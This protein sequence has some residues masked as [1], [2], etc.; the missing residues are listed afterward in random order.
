MSADRV[1]HLAR[2]A[3]APE[4][5]ILGLMSG[6]SLDGIDAALVR[7]GGSGPD[8]RIT[9]EGF[10]STPFEPD[11]RAALRQGLHGSVRE[12]CE[13][14]FAF[15][16][17]LAAASLACLAELGVDPGEVDLIASHGQT[18]WHVDPFQQGTPS[19]LQVGSPAVLAARTGCVVISD[20]RSADI[21]HGGRGAPLVSYLDHCLF[22]RPDEV[23]LLQNVG[24]IANVTVVTPRI[25]DVLAFDTGPGNVVIDAVAQALL[26]DPAG[27]DQDG[28][29]SARGAVDEALLAR[30]LE[31]PYFALEP[32][33]S[34]GR[35]VFGGPYLEAL[36]AG[37]PADRRQDLLATAVQFVARTIAAA[38]RRFVFPRWTPQRVWVSG[39]GAHNRTLMRDL[40]ELLPE[41]EV[42]SLDA[43]D[44][45]FSSDAKEAVAFAVLANETVQSRPSNVPAATGARRPAILGS[46]TL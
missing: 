12:V 43:A 29:H 1:A 22:A 27:Y 13:L 46:I 30:L 2:L 42:Q 44:V 8:T 3:Q 6:T 23:T 36:V 35:E 26:Q 32:P 31:H 28:Q 24:G 10:V 14:D 11:L 15:G 5:R 16:E 17:A 45:G 4:R 40:R 21:A 7:V 33:K 19:T 34:T 20:F 39:G 38:Y 25:E 9:L 18:L 41:L 37:Y